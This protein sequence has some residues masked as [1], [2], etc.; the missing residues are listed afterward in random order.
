MH[1]FFW[2]LIV[3]TL[4]GMSFV[5]AVN[6][7]VT[8]E[9][10]NGTVYFTYFFEG[11]EDGDLSSFSLEKPKT[12]KFIEAYSTSGETLIPSVAGDFYIIESEESTKNEN[13]TVRF[14]SP[15]LYTS[16]EN[17]NTFSTYVTFNFEPS[18][19]KFIYKPGKY[20][21]REITETFPRDYILLDNANIEWTIDSFVKEQLFLV[22]YKNEESSSNISENV[23]LILLIIPILFFVILLLFL[24]FSSNKEEKEGS[25]NKNTKNQEREESKEGEKTTEKNKEEKKED[26]KP[27]KEESP[28]DKN[29]ENPQNKEEDFES[30][31]EDFIEKYLTENEQEVVRV[32]KE[33]QGIAQNDILDYTPSLR[34]SNL[35]KIVAKLNAKKILNRIRVGKVNKIYLGER[36]DFE[37]SSSVSH[38]NVE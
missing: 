21:S 2:F 31:F 29:E 27:S 12:S 23:F 7:T 9:V 10:A 33:H 24:K 37:G 15:S 20:S 6:V 1:K 28:Q 18:N 26:K 38:D 22:S 19:L 36:L 4:L 5:S 32:V 17:T 13:I 3:S 34:K 30:F 11:G 8:S 14:Q 16:L 25:D 35:S